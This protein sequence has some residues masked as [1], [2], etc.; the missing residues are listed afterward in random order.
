MLLAPDNRA[1]PSLTEI[2]RRMA[3]DTGAENFLRQQR[4]LMGRIDSRPSLGDIAVPTLLL[5]G[6]QDGIA[7]RSHQDEM[8]AMIPG[9]RLEII[10][11]AGHLAT[12]EAPTATTAALDAFLAN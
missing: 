6:N 3:A 12:L 4:A 5:W 8:L 11:G 1:D 2:A 9:A 10:S 7:S